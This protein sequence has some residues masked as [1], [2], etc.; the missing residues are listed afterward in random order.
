MTVDRQCL[1]PAATEGLAAH[2]DAA[3]RAATVL[4][5]RHHLCPHRRRALVGQLDR[6]GI[7]YRLLGLQRDRSHLSRTG[8]DTE[9]EDLFSL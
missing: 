9:W 5:S 1:S 3:D 8:E 4:R 7:D 6:T 2:L